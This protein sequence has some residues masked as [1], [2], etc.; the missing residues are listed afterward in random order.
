MATEIENLLKTYQGPSSVVVLLETAIQLEKKLDARN[1]DKRQDVTELLSLGIS[2]MINI[3]S[4]NALFRN[5]YGNPTLDQILCLTQKEG[6]LSTLSGIGDVLTLHI[7]ME[8][9]GLSYKEFLVKEECTTPFRYAHLDTIEKE[10]LK[11]RFSEAVH[12]HR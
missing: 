4:Y 3:R 9:F 5:G 12:S 2:G 6:G 8:G 11:R 7:Q 1:K 10:R